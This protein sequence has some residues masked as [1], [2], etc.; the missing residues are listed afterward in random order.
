M[1]EKRER[2]R[3]RA[4]GGGGGGNKRDRQKKV[5]ERKVGKEKREA[6]KR[7]GEGNLPTWPSVPLCH[8]IG[9]LHRAGLGSHGPDR[10]VDSILILV[11]LLVSLSF[12]NIG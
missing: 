7:R 6:G 1:G 9:E 5:E 12:L 3:W 11:E 2:G 10:A 4:R 8:G